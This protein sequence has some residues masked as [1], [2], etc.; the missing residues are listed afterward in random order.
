MSERSDHVR[1]R[2]ASFDRQMIEAKQRLLREF[3]AA[4]IID[5][6]EKMLEED[7]DIPALFTFQCGS[8]KEF[9][10]GHARVD[11]KV[12]AITRK[13][14]SGKTYDRDWKQ[15]TLDALPGTVAELALLTEMADK[16]TVRSR[17]ERLQEKGLVTRIQRA[18]GGIEWI[19]VMADGGG[20]R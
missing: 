10:L 7:Q 6:V 2:M 17:L 20:C 1:N 8:P 16:D 12:V 5:H 19:K 3:R 4:E 13:N 14:G 15:K 11:A 9:V 18:E